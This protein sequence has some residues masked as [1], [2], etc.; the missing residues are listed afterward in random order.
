MLDCR[1]GN[2]DLGNQRL[3]KLLPVFQKG[4]ELQSAFKHH[5][6][7]LFRMSGVEN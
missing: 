2:N 6:A 3:V 5:D 4:W 1:G 7:Y